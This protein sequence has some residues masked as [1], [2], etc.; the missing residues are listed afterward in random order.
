MDQKVK[1][2]RKKIIFTV[3]LFAV[4]VLCIAIAYADY[5]SEK[6]AENVV[7]PA[8][9]ATAV[10]ENGTSNAN[11]LSST[12]TTT[13]S[14]VADQTPSPTSYSAA[15]QVQ[16]KNI[17]E[18]DNNTEAYIRVAIVPEWTA[19]VTP[20]AGTDVDVTL[21]TPEDYGLEDFGE[22]TDIS[23]SA[24]DTSYTM[25][26]VTFTLDSSWESYWFFNTTDGYFYYRKKLA[27]GS[28]TEP[29]LASVKLSASTYDSMEEYGIDLEVD[30]LTD[31][32]QTQGGA[33]DARWEDARLTI[34]SDGTLATASPTPTP[35]P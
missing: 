9:V 7:T 19:T 3:L 34:E 12:Y 32:I 17:D 35:D 14:L 33:V 27:P 1:H 29:L 6:T 15:K 22:L 28:T 25:G 13:L 4:L 18:N 24:G 20:T 8:N 21:G 26:D 31:A 30:V 10:I 16:I 23:L 2:R 5:K 11:I